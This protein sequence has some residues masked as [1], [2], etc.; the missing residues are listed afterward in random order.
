[1]LLPVLLSM[2]S[3][4]RNSDGVTCDLPDQKCC[5]AN[6][7]HLPLLTFQIF[8]WRPQASLKCGDACPIEGLMSTVPRHRPS[9]R[10]WNAKSLTP[11]SQTQI[12][13]LLY[14]EQKHTLTAPANLAH[15]ARLLSSAL[16]MAHNAPSSSSRWRLW[17]QTSGLLSGSSL[18]L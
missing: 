10:R 13:P 3:M 15:R 4:S 16:H 12:A 2:R 7:P 5:P 11:H 1:M 6:P 17:R 9:M 8:L 14:L 18:G